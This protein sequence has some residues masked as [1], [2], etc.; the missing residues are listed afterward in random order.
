MKRPF[1]VVAHNRFFTICAYRLTGCLASKNFIYTIVDWANDRRGPDS[2][3]FGPHCNYVDPR[4][5][6]KALKQLG[7]GRMHRKICKV[8]GKY[9]GKHIWEGPKLETSRRRSCAL[10][11]EKIIKP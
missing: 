9:F 8:R 11:L 3:I 2:M 6:A 5:A 4:E 10:D 1:P 7:D